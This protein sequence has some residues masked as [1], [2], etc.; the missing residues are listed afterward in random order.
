VGAGGRVGGLARQGGAAAAGR[1]R[2]FGLGGGLDRRAYVVGIAR[3]DDADRL[4]LVHGRVG[5][6]EE[7]RAGVE[8]DVAADHLLELAFEVVHVRSLYSVLAAHSV[9]GT[10]AV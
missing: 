6:V 2:D 10:I 9:P 8:A 7:A 3:D 1:D 5:R 4:H